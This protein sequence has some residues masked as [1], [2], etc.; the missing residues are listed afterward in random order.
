MPWTLTACTLLA[1]MACSEPR[2]LRASPERSCLRDRGCPPPSPLPPCPAGLDALPV[3]AVVG[4]R[5][6]MNRTVAVRGPLVV[7]ISN[8]TELGCVGSR[9][10]NRC[11]SSLQLGVAAPSASVAEARAT[12]LQLFGAVGC[13]GDESLLCC[14]VADNGQDAIAQGMVRMIGP[15]W[16]LEPFTLCAPSAALNH[17]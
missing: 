12:T 14:R 3:A 9:C 7:G 13:S 17:E 1:G 11:S 10:C 8:C 6:M 5:T 4:D 2:P 15:I 16:A